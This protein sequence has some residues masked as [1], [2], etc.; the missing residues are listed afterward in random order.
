MFAPVTDRGSL[1]PPMRDDIYQALAIDRSAT[2]EQRTIDITTTGRR[3]GE[4][5]RIE[6][7]FYRF[8][9]SIYLSGLPGPRP[10]AWLLNLSAKQ[11]LNFHLKHGVIADLPAIAT[12]ITDPGE[13]RSILADF[14]EDFNERHG[15]D[16][17]W[18]EAVL[19]EWVARSPLAKVSFEPTD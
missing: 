3:S 19:D 17:E 2:L 7:V 15:P 9:D 10:R 6:T 11:Y 13:R 16:S 8:D 4:P 1:R 5:R 14:V 18:P 12:V